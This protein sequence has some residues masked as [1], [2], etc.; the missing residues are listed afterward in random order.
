M[1]HTAEPSDRCDGPPLADLRVVDFTVARAGPTCVRQL[2]DWGAEV[3]R[4]DAPQHLD[5]ADGGDR[6]GA[7]FQNLH[8][9]K[10]SIT[11]DLK[12]ERGREIAYEL[13]RRADVV[14]ENMRPPVKFRLGI[15]YET[16]SAINPRIVY[17]SISAFGQG[18]PY[19]DRAGVDQ[20]AQGVGGLM[21][22]TGQP[23]HG[24]LRVGIAV[25]D[26]AAGLFLAVGI[27]V[28]LHERERSGR[29]QWVRTS[30]LEAMIGMMDFQAARWTVDGEIPG[31]EGNHHPTHTPMGCF[32]TADGH[33]NIAAH[34]NR[35]WAEFCR[36]AGLERLLDDPRFTDPRHRSLHRTAL[37]AIIA[38]RMRSRTSDEWVTLL[39]EAGV[40]AGAVHTVDQVFADPQVEHLDLVQRV[41][42]ATR[43][44]IGLVRNSVSLSAASRDIRA[45]SPDAGEHT[46]AI[47]AE[48]GLSAIEIDELRRTGAV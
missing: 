34:G 46:E 1:V 16:L 5:V 6:H 23:G 38:E 26:L 21:S 19:G 47:L 12:T 29:G 48:L 40:P 45:A 36:I 7:D 32:E 42:H 33:V 43:G 27:L 11:L 31:Q 28:A 41:Q 4:V 17:G 8:R 20:I 9:N 3:I 35:A 39:N 2:A 14:V 22:V 44:D 13:V 18:G 15:D 37:N 10:R 30:L 24:P 25:S